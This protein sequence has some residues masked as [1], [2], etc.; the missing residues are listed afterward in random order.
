MSSSTPTELIVFCSESAQRV[1][2]EGDAR[3]SRSVARPLNQCE[4]PWISV[5]GWLSAAQ[6]KLPP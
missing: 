3:V 2:G 4:E 1:S 6:E 5:T